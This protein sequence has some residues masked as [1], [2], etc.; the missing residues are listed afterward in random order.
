MLQRCLDT[1]EAIA[2]MR[3][4]FSTLYIGD[5]QVPQRLMI[6]LAE[7]GVVLLMPSLLQTTEQCAFGL[8]VITVM[9]QNPLWGMP[10]SPSQGG[11]KLASLPPL[12]TTKPLTLC[13]KIVR[14]P[15]S[16]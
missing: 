1:T 5:A 9:R 13:A 16:T 8:K 2:A 14:A 4:A 3:V 11:G 6:D 7:Q 10:R 15:E 12:L